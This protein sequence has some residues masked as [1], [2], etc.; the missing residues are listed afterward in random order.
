M[1]LFTLDASE[2]EILSLKNFEVL[3]TYMK[4][5][6]PQKID[7]SFE[8]RVIFADI[9]HPVISNKTILIERVVIF[10]NYHFS[11][12]IFQFASPSSLQRLYFQN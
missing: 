10:E 4:E 7:A 12:C 1:I 6:I 9:R 3:M 11:V 2:A 8:Y 5:T